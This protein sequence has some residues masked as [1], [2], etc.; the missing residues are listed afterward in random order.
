MQHTARIHGNFTNNSLLDVIK[1]VLQ[2]PQQGR[3]N[4]RNTHDGGWGNIYHNK[5]RIVEVNCRSLR[6]DQA[7]ERIL[8][9]QGGDYLYY[10]L[11]IPDELEKASVSQKLFQSLFGSPETTILRPTVHTDPDFKRDLRNQLIAAL[12]PIADYLIAEALEKTGFELDNVTAEQ[13]SAFGLA[14]TQVTPEAYRERI[15]IVMEGFNL[16]G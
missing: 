13:V 7:L 6:S 1:E 4:I 15:R 5:Q 14:L 12:G 8:S 16:N 11:K 2:L 9:W 10:A 3:M